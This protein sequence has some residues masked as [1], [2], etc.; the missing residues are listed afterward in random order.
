MSRPEARGPPVATGPACSSRSATGSRSGFPET[1]GN[2]IPSSPAWTY[3]V[4]TVEENERAIAGALADQ[5]FAAIDFLFGQDT[6]GPPQCAFG[7][8][9]E[10]IGTCGVRQLFPNKQTCCAACGRSDKGQKRKSRNRQQG[11]LS[12][13]G[14]LAQ[15]CGELG[16]G[17]ADDA[18]ACAVRRGGGWE[19]R[20]IITWRPV[21]GLD[22]SANSCG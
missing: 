11:A 18:G 14:G 21:G 1:S 3:L 5:G 4:A 19:R 6:E 17:T 15:P 8:R 12:G 16:F 2:R 20:W 13:G 10:V 22:N 7:A 9:A